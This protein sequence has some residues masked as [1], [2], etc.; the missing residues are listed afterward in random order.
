LKANG[1]AHAYC[2]GWQ[3]AVEVLLWYLNLNRA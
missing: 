3:Q 2:Y 1:N